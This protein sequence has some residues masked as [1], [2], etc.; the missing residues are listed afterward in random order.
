VSLLERCEE[1]AAKEFAERSFWEKEAFISR[2][3]PVCVISR[4]AAAGYDAVN[5]RMML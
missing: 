5:V 1:F 2:A 3:H 4:Q